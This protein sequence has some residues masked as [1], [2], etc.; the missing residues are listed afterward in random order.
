MAYGI[1][2]P[3]SYPQPQYTQPYN[4]QP[5][6]QQQQNNGGMIWVRGEAEAKSF[7]VAPNTTVA[8]WDSENQIIYLKSADASGMPTIKTIDYTVR[9]QISPVQND[10]VTKA[11]FEEFSNRIMKQIEG[12]TYKRNNYK[13]NKNE[14][15]VDN[16]GQ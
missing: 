14:S 9:E 15:G 6:Q 16:N 4:I 5:Y 8:L 3:G 12:I 7:G 1:G 2:Y 11:D 10:Y 13:Y